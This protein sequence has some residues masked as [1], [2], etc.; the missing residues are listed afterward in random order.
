MIGLIGATGS[1]GRALVVA[2]KQKGTDFRC[3]VRDKVAAVEK[4]GGDVE[5]VE[6]D[7]ADAASVE[8]GLQGCRK[9]F[10]LSGHSPVMVEQQ[11]NAAKAVGAKHMVK[12][13]GGSFICQ[14]NSP[15]MIGRWAWPP[16]ATWRAMATT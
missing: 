3:L 7:L 15:A 5:M 12:L 11:M 10:L 8:S 13:S 1:T 14:Q 16:R 9:V 6:S 4:L 2:L